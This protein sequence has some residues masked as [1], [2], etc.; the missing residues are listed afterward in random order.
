MSSP[1]L[2]VQGGDI[3]NFNYHLKQVQG[4]TIEL[5]VEECLEDLINL[6]WNNKPKGN[7]DNGILAVQKQP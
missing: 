4:M 6:S 3:N 7:S 5:K 1:C 2:N